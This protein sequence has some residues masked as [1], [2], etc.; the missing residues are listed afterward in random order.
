MGPGRAA[1]VP[2][3]PSA[4]LPIV[5][6]ETFPG[7]KC[8]E[9]DPHRRFS[10]SAVVGASDYPIEALLPG[11]GAVRLAGSIAACPRVAVRTAYGPIGVVPVCTDGQLS[12]NRSERRLRLIQPLLFHF[13]F[14]FVLFSFGS[15]RLL[16]APVSVLS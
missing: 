5:I 16:R 11:P 2:L 8:L 7:L 3:F 10:M 6:A 1:W 14:W 9:P 13:P 12:A 4:F 15:S